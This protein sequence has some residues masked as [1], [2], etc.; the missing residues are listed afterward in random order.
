MSVVVLDANAVISHGR[1]FAERV[2]A[3]RG[4]YE[5]IVLPRSV[6]R[7]LVDDVL[8]TPTAPPN[9]RDSARTIRGLVDEGVLDVREP[10]FGS[11][12]DVVDEA[13][14]R[15]ADDSLPE[16]EV[17]ADQYVP[18]LVCELAGETPVILVTNDAKLRRV[19]TE[20]ASRRGVGDEITL[21][22]PGTVL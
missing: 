13:R 16:H 10:D 5:A 19:V 21:A 12:A 1:A 11:Y 4:E 8:D 20:I 6:E 9:H 15:I 17:Q 22:D 2:R 14:R 18:A 7:E 3:T